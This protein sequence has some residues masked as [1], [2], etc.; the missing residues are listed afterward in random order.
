MFLALLLAAA[1]QGAPADKPKKV[2]Q[3]IV[4]EGVRYRVTTFGK[5]VEVANK[6]ASV[7]YTVDERDAQRKAAQIITGC[8]LVDELPST[9]ARTRGKLEC[10]DASPQPVR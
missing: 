4:L 3:H 8:K 9:D 2:T 6:S 5:S 1:S 7:R 10:D